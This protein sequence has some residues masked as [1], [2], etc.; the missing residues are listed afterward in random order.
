MDPLRNSKTPESILIRV[1]RKQNTT[2]IYQEKST[3]FL[4]KTW[5]SIRKPKDF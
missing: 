2:L 5:E 4:Q 1:I 3:I